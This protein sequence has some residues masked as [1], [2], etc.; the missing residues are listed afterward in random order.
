MNNIVFR[1]NSILNKAILVSV[2]ILVVVYAISV[3]I[4]LYRKFKDSHKDYKLDDMKF[5][6]VHNQGSVF[7]SASYYNIEKNK[8][9]FLESIHHGT[10]YC[11]YRILDCAFHEAGKKKLFNNKSKAFFRYE[12]EFENNRGAQINT[13]INQHVNNNTGNLAFNSNVDSYNQTFNIERWNEEILI[14]NDLS[15]DDKLLLTEV[16]T[17]LKQRKAV[18]KENA[19]Q[20]LNIISNM[21]TM[22]AFGKNLIEILTKFI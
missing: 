7:I 10:I 19:K 11:D 6:K 14:S 8:K 16:I 2:I 13:Q 12:T 17:S 15:K 20:C 5:Q 18:T 22:F 3:S 9:R 1:I 21:N 4:F